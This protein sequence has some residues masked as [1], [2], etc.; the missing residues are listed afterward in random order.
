MMYLM[1]LVLLAAVSV[2]AYS[3]GAPTSQCGEMTPS[4]ALSTATSPGH[5]ASPQDSATFP[6]QVTFSKTCF[7]A[8]DSVDGKYM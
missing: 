7:K 6:Y 3:G 5:G 4:A 2:D 1:L 8:K